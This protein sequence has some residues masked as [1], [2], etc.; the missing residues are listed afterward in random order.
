MPLIEPSGEVTVGCNVADTVDCPWLKVI[1]DGENM[2]W[3]E[4]EICL[5]P[6]PDRV[7]STFAVKFPPPGVVVTAGL[8]Q[9]TVTGKVCTLTERIKGAVPV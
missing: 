7:Q 1:V 3:L 8:L 2:F 5:A 6:L 4:G 9:L